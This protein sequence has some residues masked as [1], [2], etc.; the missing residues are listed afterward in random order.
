[1]LPY[2]VMASPR[3]WRLARWAPAAALLGQS[4]SAL[5][6]DTRVPL[7]SSVRG[8]HTP[9]TVL[10]HG[11]DSSKQTWTGVLSKLHEASVPALALDQ[12]GHGESPLGDPNTFSTEALARDIIHAVEV[13]NEIPRPWIL[14]GHSM[15]GRVAMAV[16]EISMREAPDRLAAV[17]I[18][19]MDCRNRNKW[20]PQPQES[21]DIAP[22][23]REF[24]TEAAAV[25]ALEKHY[26]ADRVEGWLG[27]RVRSIGGGPRV[28]SDVNPQAQ[29]LARKRVL[30][31][32]VATANWDALAR[33]DLPFPVHLWV[34]GPEAYG[35][36]VVDWDGPDGIRDMEKRI[37]SVHVREF[38]EGG[39]S[40]HN[41]AIDG[42]CKA[43]LEVIDDAAKAAS[44]RPASAASGS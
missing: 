18:E 25:A 35:G 17:V 12:R 42:F 31:S 36:T 37:P 2:A 6:F 16:A 4:S 34:A 40:I 39:H 22:F 29:R 28:W 21:K 27:S 13:T 24:A 15:G 38:T 41:T 1:M 23:E 43:L 19:D 5:S 14:V 11:L 44:E 9:T 20:G 30:A 8:R 7:T 33:A 10:V 26:D 3:L 32:D